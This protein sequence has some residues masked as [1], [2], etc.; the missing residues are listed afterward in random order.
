MLRDASDPGKPFYLNFM[1]LIDGV[2][3]VSNTFFHGM[4]HKV[5]LIFKL[6][7]AGDNGKLDLITVGY[8]P[9]MGLC[10]M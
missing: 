5:W 6:N 4:T 10:Q 8:L 3:N 7:T 2:K 9:A 1:L